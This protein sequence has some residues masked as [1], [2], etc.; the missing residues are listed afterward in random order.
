MPHSFHTI[1]VHAIWSTKNR[2]SFIQSNVE[3]KIYHYMKNQ[4]KDSGCPVRIINGMPDHVHCLFL[5]NPQ[6]ALTDVIK[7][8]KGSTSHWI[9][10]QDM[11]P[12]KFSW[13]VGGASYSV[14][15]SVKEK[16]YKYI[17]N[18]KKHHEH[19]SFQEEYEEFI[20]LHQFSNG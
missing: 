3:E 5:L 1:W 11:I 10:Q 13:Q 20:K 19:K 15:E 9:N 6:K 12:Q 7:Q 14:S 16:V 4:F 18:Q 17:A 2:K 8:V